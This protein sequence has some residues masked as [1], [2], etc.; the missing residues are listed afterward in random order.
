MKFDFRRWLH[1]K[2][3][4]KKLSEKDIDHL[5][6]GG[7]TFRQECPVWKEL[8]EEE[9]KQKGNKDVSR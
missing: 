7:L 4:R 6:K 3:S 1:L 2:P 9:N 8:E 5:E